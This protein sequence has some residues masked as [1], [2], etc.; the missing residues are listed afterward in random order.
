MFGASRLNMVLITNLKKEYHIV[1][2]FHASKFKTINNTVFKHTVEVTKNDSQMLHNNA[3][4]LPTTKSRYKCVQH[5]SLECQRG[6]WLTIDLLR[7]SL[8][9]NVNLIC[10]LGNGLSERFFKIKYIPSLILKEYK[11]IDVYVVN[12]WEKNNIYNIIITL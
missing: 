7:S 2:P 4:T 12:L 10:T 1:L 5:K 9:D 6:W 11:Y 3:C 8:N